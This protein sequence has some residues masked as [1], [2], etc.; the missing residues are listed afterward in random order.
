MRGKKNEPAFVVHT[1]ELVAQLHGT[2]VA[3]LAAQTRANALKLFPRL[4]W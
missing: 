1:A 2:S 4:K 3:E